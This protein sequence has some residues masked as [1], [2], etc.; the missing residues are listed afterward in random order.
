MS[1]I[2]PT[3]PLLSAQ[4]RSL[5]PYNNP[6]TH[7][8]QGASSFSRTH[9]NTN[10]HFH[11]F[12]NI[13][14]SQHPSSFTQTRQNPADAFN[15]YLLYIMSNEND[16]RN[17]SEVNIN[18]LLENLP[19]VCREKFEKSFAIIIGGDNIVKAGTGIM[20]T[21]VITLLVG[22]STRIDKYIDLSTFFSVVFPM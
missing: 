7:S 11:F 18:I 22:F 12:V 20:L 17:L 4:E 19:P 3:T 6:N 2:K 8:A 21:S 9:Q 14:Q 5:L 15:A 10:N 13:N 16:L 1:S